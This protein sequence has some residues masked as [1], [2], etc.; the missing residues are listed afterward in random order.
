M[1][2]TPEIT[3]AEPGRQAN[4]TFELQPNSELGRYRLGGVLGSGGMGVVWSAYD[5]DLDREVA[6]KV[7][8]GI[9]DTTA[10][11]RLLCEARAMARLA[12]P[13]VV[14]VHEV[15]TDRNRDFVVMELVAGENLEAWLATKP[16]R[17]DVLDA[18]VAAGR[19]LAAAH[20]AGL[21]HRDFKPHNVLR[22]R[23]GRVLVTDFGLARDQPAGAV[24]AHDV[25]PLTSPL[26]L[27]ST[28]RGA[29][30][31]ALASPLTDADALVGTPAYMAPEQLAGAAC[32]AA[33]DQFAFCVAAWQ[34]LVG[35]R[36][37]DGEGLAER[38]AAIETGR[39][40]RADAL[41][42]RLRAILT[43]GLAF[44]PAARWSDL[45]ELLAALE[46]TRHPRARRYALVVA[47]VLAAGGL[48]A[49]AAVPRGVEPCTGADRALAATWNDAI[50]TAGQ[51]AF[52][53]TQLPYAAFA[54]NHTAQTLDAYGRDWVAMH[55]ATCRASE[56]GE[57]STATLDLRMSCLA[58]RLAELRAA[59][60][61]FGHADRG[62]VAKATT[63]ADGLG[64]IDACADL[65]ALQAV[66]PPPNVAVAGIVADT[67]AELARA[68]VLHAAGQSHD[69]LPVARAAADRAQTIGYLPL[70][71]EAS[72]E[73]GE[74]E[75][76]VGDHAAERTLED[77]FDAAEA[78]DD[79]AVAA[80]AA[81]RL[82]AVAGGVRSRWD[83]AA[84][85]SRIASAEARRRTSTPAERAR[86]AEVAAFL[87][88]QAGHVA[89]GLARDREALELY[90]QLRDD[91]GA[92][93]SHVALGWDFLKAG[94]LD[95]ARPELAAALAIDERIYAPNHPNTAEVLQAMAELQLKSHDVTGAVATARRALAIDDAALGSDSK[96]SGDVHFLLGAAREDVAELRRA[97]A[98]R[99]RVLGVDHP[100]TA[101]VHASL[102]GIAAR[103]ERYADA[104]SELRT[105]LAIDQRT[106]QPGSLELARVRLMLGQAL[107]G[108]R[109]YDEALVEL[110]A[111]G[112]ETPFSASAHRSIGEVLVQLHRPAEAVVELEADLAIRKRTL[113][114]DSPEV[115]NALELLGDAHLA[116]HRY[117][118]AADE[119][120]RALAIDEIKQPDQR[121][122][123][124][125][126]SELARARAAR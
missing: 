28:L 29:R 62:V 59:G 51:R 113:G 18:I 102:G 68:R 15:G 96:A 78:A 25:A 58:Q 42:R 13:N 4:E 1:V 73:A 104:I 87:A 82:A 115:A 124:D 36:P 72:L 69:A 94:R 112:P 39:P 50:K 117:R 30:A 114:A 6:I 22:A 10:R 79:A 98:I 65:P 93:R 9:E 80:R 118:E 53:A 108:A 71:A 95:E 24:E 57:Q 44:D 85:W 26:A 123:A 126:R 14:S 84:R 105:A 31:F 3:A 7:L 70:A 19:G 16:P 101:A 99:E 23:D 86:A 41:P 47:G 77:A 34:A 40:G 120:A 125:L 46:R 81:A 35:T 109:D 90:E 122:L 61:L 76:V 49:H 55:T 45:D 75:E 107:A 37:F 66:V 110:R 20:A 97:L 74:L 67:R 103:H 56:A 106:L 83:E 100:L 38:L 89:D 116:L 63:I 91:V 11:A 54:W 64:P 52:L 48:A 8:R 33:A 27:A 5:P 32:T 21:V 121:V 119:L 60:D 92:A 111:V 2:A 17:E 43:R 12:H 88:F